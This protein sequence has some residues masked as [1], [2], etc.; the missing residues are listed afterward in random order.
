MPI[1]KIKTIDMNKNIYK[2]YK[3][4]QSTFMANF[5]S[6]NINFNRRIEPGILIK[7]VE[8]II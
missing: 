8:I 6:V 5:G 4:D 1:N 7:K 2:K 3:V